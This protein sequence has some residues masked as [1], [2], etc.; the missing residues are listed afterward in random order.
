MIRPSGPAARRLSIGA[1]YFAATAAGAFAFFGLPH[2]R[3]AQTGP[4]TLRLEELGRG[5]AV[6]QAFPVTNDGLYA[7]EVQV[8]ASSPADVRLEF[9]VSL[10]A[11]GA[12]VAEIRGIR[13][14]RDL[15]GTSWIALDFPAVEA[16]AGTLCTLVLRALRVSAATDGGHPDVALIGTRGVPIRSGYLRVGDAE[17]WGSLRLV[18]RATGDTLAGALGGGALAG[19][20]AAWPRPLVL[21]LVLAVYSALFPAVIHA[22]L[23]R[24]PPVSAPG[25]RR[26][27]RMLSAG[28]G[29]GLLAALSGVLWTAA[30]ER[31]RVELIDRLG[32][33]QVQSS[34]PLHEFIQVLP[35]EIG[36]ETK[37]AL[38]A[39]STTSVRWP[40]TPRPGARLATSLGLAPAIWDAGGDGTVFR[41]E[42][43]DGND[44]VELFV[45]HVNPHGVSADRR[46]IPVDVDLSPFA[47]RTVTLILTTEPSPSGALPDSSYDWALW[48]EPII[49]PG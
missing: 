38:F 19:L 43:A 44:R 25:P 36:L 20:P 24:R 29:A 17:R 9:E 1:W 47:G 7:I 12:A 40:V 39:H 3:T 4:P 15:S 16:S 49:G 11:G 8:Q 21:A 6:A 18:A 46:W 34:G 35:V 5:T 23:G 42:V 27:A 32:D 30:L 31:R 22:L 45:R 2:G 41:I 48:G 13:D 37:R 33:A 26:R 14:I 10:A 28:L